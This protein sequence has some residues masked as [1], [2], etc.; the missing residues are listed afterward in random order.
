MARRKNL[1]I[2]EVGT[3]VIVL[4]EDAAFTMDTEEHGTV[5]LQTVGWVYKLTRTVVTLAGEKS[6]AGDYHRALTAIPRSLVRSVDSL[7]PQQGL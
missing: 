1:P 7:H 6:Q 4:W 3:L 5:L 2:P